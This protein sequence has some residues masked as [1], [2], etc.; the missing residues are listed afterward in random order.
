MY[1]ALLKCDYQ[2]GGNLSHS[3]HN[4]TLE[5]QNVSAEGFSGKKKKKKTALKQTKSDPGFRDGS[6]KTTHNKCIP[7]RLT[8]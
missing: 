8:D 5:A 3:K 4:P 6:E 2:W 1:T 7:L